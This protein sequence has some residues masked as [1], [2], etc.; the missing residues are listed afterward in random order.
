[1]NTLRR[2]VLI[3][4]GIG[5]ISGVV[6]GCGD[7]ERGGGRQQGDA[8]AQ[9]PSSDGRDTAAGSPSADTAGRR[10]PVTGPDGSRTFTA[11]DGTPTT[12]LPPLPDRT[13]VEAQDGCRGGGEDAPPPSPGLSASPRDGVVVFDYSVGESSGRCR[14]HEIRLTLYVSETGQSRTWN[15]PIRRSGRQEVEVPEYYEH[16]PDVARASIITHDARRSEVVSVLIR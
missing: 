14:P 3:L 10:A 6:M 9:R 7:E 8:G 13:V 15:Y 4:V 11:E 12:I 2:F 1:M 5:A 16:E